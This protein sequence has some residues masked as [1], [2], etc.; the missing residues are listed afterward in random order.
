MTY[1][2]GTDD[3]F[4]VTW[5]PFYL[6]PTSPAKGIPWSERAAQKFGADRVEA[7]EARLR[8]I[9]T[10]EGINFS[11]SGR[12]GNTRDSHRVIQLA[13]AKEDAAGKEGLQSAV[14]KEIMR[15]YF[16]EGGDITSHEML[17]AAAAKGGLD[18]A[19]T[20]AW[21]A[22]GKGGPEV[23]REVGQANALGVSGVP[24]F[25]FDEKYQMGGAQDPSEFLAQ[26]IAIKEGNA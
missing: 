20:K 9:G 7:I 19:E 4:T 5:A 11:F 8:Q 22:E 15:S 13:K 2:G 6:D 18:A 14:V 17:I 23:D 25:I 24:H 26:I 1:P 16:E 21:L 12:I 10:M 3:T